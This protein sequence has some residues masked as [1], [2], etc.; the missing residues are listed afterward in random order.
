MKLSKHIN[1]IV[2][3]LLHKLRVLHGYNI[4]YFGCIR[5][6]FEKNLDCDYITSIKTI[7]K[8]EKTSQRWESLITFSQKN[9][10]NSQTIDNKFSNYE[11][12]SQN[13]EYL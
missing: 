10:Q 12:F 7:P 2:M 13:N 9:S 1:F 8:N 4:L 11:S 3:S 5:Y 6:F